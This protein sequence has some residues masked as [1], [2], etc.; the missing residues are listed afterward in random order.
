MQ[1]ANECLRKDLKSAQKSSKTMRKGLTAKVASLDTNPQEQR[2]GPGSLRYPIGGSE[3]VKVLKARPQMA[4]PH[5]NS[6]SWHRSTRLWHTQASQLWTVLHSGPVMVKLSVWL[7]FVCA[8]F[9][10]TRILQD[11]CR[12]IVFH[13]LIMG[14]SNLIAISPIVHDFLAICRHRNLEG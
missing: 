14:S 4:F 5:C 2:D 12:T 11:F 10:Q 13:V 3:Q 7:D 6:S 9:G 1:R 8:S